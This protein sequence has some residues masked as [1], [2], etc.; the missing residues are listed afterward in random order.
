MGH[1]VCV[2]KC[3]RVWKASR[4][5]RGVGCGQLETQERNPEEESARRRQV[6]VPLSVA[7]YAAAV[8]SSTWGTQAVGANDCPS[9]GVA[10][11]T[12]D[13]L[14]VAAGMTAAYALAPETAGRVRNAAQRLLAGRWG[15]SD[16]VSGPLAAAGFVAAFVVACWVLRLLFGGAGGVSASAGA[17]SYLSGFAAES[18]WSAVWP[19]RSRAGLLLAP[20]IA[21]AIVALNLPPWR[22]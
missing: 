2:P 5:M 11:A 7:V 19:G 21:W 15:W 4:Q 6:L 18:A 10:K 22:C 1:P 20:F 9:P 17:A 14:I 16:R 8:W 3:G 13:L 12:Q